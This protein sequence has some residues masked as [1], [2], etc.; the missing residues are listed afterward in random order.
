MENL[1]DVYLY[2]SLIHRCHPYIHFFMLLTIFTNVILPIFRNVI[3]IFMDDG[4][5]PCEPIRR[6]ESLTQGFE[7]GDVHQA[8]A[9]TKLAKCYT[10]NKYP[11]AL[12]TTD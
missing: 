11:T 8:A 9:S 2:S 5:F 6:L 3:S 4:C 7:R 1:R 12:T 10:D